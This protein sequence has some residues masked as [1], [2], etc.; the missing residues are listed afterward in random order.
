ML[1]PLT[2]LLDFGIGQTI[3]DA[4]FLPRLDMRVFANHTSE[5]WRRWAE[6][7]HGQSQF[8]MNALLLR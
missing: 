6:P 5:L 3:F 8:L 2:L 1:P 7:Y 4:V